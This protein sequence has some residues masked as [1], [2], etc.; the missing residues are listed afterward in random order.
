MSCPSCCYSQV[1]H[2]DD[3]GFDDGPLLR[4]HRFPPTVIALGGELVQTW[5]NVKETDW[6]GEYQLIP[7]PA[8]PLTSPRPN[9]SG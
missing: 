9:P 5:P 6:C 3:N 1:D 2:E 7:P 4:C 8:V